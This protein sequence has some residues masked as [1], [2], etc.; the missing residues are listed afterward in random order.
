[1]QLETGQLLVAAP[2]MVD[3]NFARTVVVLCDIDDDGA[4]GLVLNRPSQ[5]PVSEYLPQWT[6]ATPPVVFVGGPVQPEI[7]VGFIEHSGQA[8]IGFTSVS[9]SVG[10]FDLATPPELV[11]GAVSLLRVFSGYSGWARGQLESEIEAG[12]WIIIE[13]ASSDHFSAELDTL[14]SEVL[15]RQGGELALLAEYPTDPSLN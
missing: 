13:A 12:D 9:G 2:A 3:P 10:L 7:A 14:W 6:A 11:E 1:M 8:P 15:R 4:I 5:S